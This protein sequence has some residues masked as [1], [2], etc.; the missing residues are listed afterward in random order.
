MVQQHKETL[1]VLSLTLL[2][3]HLFVLIKVQLMF[4]EEEMATPS[5]ILAWNI[6]QAEVPG[7]LRSTGS[8]RVRH[9]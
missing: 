7:G 9:G 5:S 1:N 3:L 2:G 6:A 8:G 4:L